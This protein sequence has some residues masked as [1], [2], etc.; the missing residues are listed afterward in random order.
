MRWPRPLSRRL[1]LLLLSP[2]YPPDFS[3]ISLQAWI[4]A[5][6]LQRRGWN[7][8]VVA[9]TLFWSFRKDPSLPLDSETNVAR[10]R[11][12]PRTLQRISSRFLSSETQAVMEAHF[13]TQLA[14]RRYHRDRPA[15]ILSLQRSSHI[16]GEELARRW[17]APFVPYFLDPFQTNPF[18]NDTPWTRRWYKRKMESLLRHARVALFPTAEMAHRELGQRQPLVRHAI[19]PHAVD[20]SIVQPVRHPPRDQK[21]TNVCAAHFGALYGKR[22]LAPLLAGLDIMCR[23]SP[24]Q[25][26]KLRIDLYMSFPPKTDVSQ[27]A[28]HGAVIRWR[29]EIP[30]REA[31]A[32]QAA[33]HFLLLIDAPVTPCDFLPSKLLDGIAQGKYV[34][35]ITP[36]SSVSTRMLRAYGHRAADIFSPEDIARSLK[37][38][39]EEISSDPQRSLRPPVHE[40]DDTHIIGV[41]HTTLTSAARA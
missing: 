40:F 29:R 24:E 31:I 36:P 17:H 7:V 3:P 12:L 23:Q 13:V 11:P 21:G 19:V 39:I 22:T 26:E 32:R 37:S 5:R 35:G 16:A 9:G 25:Y 6:G 28:A 14:R 20:R 27:S 10:L 41:L 30:Y 8:H 33:Y 15:L 38:S 2:S 18:H 4:I 1:R 34:L